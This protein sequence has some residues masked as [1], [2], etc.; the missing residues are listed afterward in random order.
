MGDR[1]LNIKDLSNG[2]RRL[3][4]TRVWRLLDANANRARE[5]L[6]V[7]EDTARFVLAQP[8]ASSALRHLRHRLDHLVR[9]N[10]G[11]LLKHRD[12]ENDSGRQNPSARHLQGVSSLMA[13]NFKRCE[14]ALRVLEEYGRVLSPKIVRGIQE[15]RFNVY[16][17]EKKLLQPRS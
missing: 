4:Q 5:G 11:A 8:R 6:R 16:Q 7:I 13:A 9:Q 2:G 15:I 12:V 1:A 17:W 3:A 10:Y 14:E